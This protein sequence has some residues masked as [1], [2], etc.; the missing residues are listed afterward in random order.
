MGQVV[1]FSGHS[2]TTSRS[3]GM[4]AS[5]GRPVASLSFLAS[6]KDAVLRPAR[7][8][9]RCDTEHPTLPARSDALA[10]LATNGSRGWVSDMTQT[11]STRNDLR[12]AEIFLLEMPC[13]ANALVECAM[14]KKTDP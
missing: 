1:Q 14:G 5:I 6:G 12:Q 8:L 10:S 7:R 3:P 9:R 4:N 2:S 13:R 11:I